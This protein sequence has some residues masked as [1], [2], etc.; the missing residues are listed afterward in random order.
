[1]CVSQFSFFIDKKLLMLFSVHQKIS[2]FLNF[3]SMKKLLLMT[4]F[5]VAIMVGTWL[6]FHPVID[7]Y[8]ETTVQYDEQTGTYFAEVASRYV[9][10]PTAEMKAGMPISYYKTE[11]T[12]ICV[13]S[14][15][16]TKEEI[17]AKAER[18]VKVGIG[19]GGIICWLIGVLIL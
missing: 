2:M 9:V 16:E 19:V 3:Y 12:S 10:K 11:G 6:S 14:K 8:G 15:L 5:V 1:M 7:E 13:S 17:L 18:D 4:L